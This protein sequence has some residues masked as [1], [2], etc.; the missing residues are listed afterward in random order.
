MES[1]V[2]IKDLVLARNTDNSLIVTEE[3]VEYLHTESDAWAD[4]VVG[5]CGSSFL[6][7][8]VFRQNRS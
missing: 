1:K 4:I 8:S 2:H 7:A 3:K 6:K 5:A